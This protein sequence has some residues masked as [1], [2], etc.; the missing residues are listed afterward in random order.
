MKISFIIICALII[1]ASMTDRTINEM[2]PTT[3]AQTDSIVYR[4]T[5]IAFSW[6]R[7]ADIQLNI[8]VSDTGGT[9]TLANGDYAYFCIYGVAQPHI[10]MKDDASIIFRRFIYSFVSNKITYRYRITLYTTGAWRKEVQVITG[11]A[12]IEEPLTPFAQIVNQ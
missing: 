5:C 12:W 9:A 2:K 4:D 7:Q 11:G 10:R 6:Q 1:A 3:Q 8:L